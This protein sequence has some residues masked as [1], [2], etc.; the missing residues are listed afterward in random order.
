[1]DYILVKSKKVKDYTKDHDEV[2]RVPRKYKVNLSLE[3]CLF[4]VL[5]KKFLVFMVF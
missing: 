2:S 1:M 5:A 4:R 3:K